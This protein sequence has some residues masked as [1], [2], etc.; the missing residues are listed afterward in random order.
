[1]SVIAAEERDARWLRSSPGLILAVGV[2]IALVIAVGAILIVLQPPLG[3]MATLVATLA[4]TSILSLAAGFFLY[5]R[6][7]AS[8]PSLSL[9]LLLTYAWAAILTLINVW[10]LAGLMFYSKHDLALAGILLIFAGIIA[11]TFGVFVAAR[12]TGDLRQLSAAAHRLADGDLTARATVSGRDEV[13]QVAVAFNEMADQMQLASE[14][15]ADV[16]NLRRDLIAWTSHD[17]RTPLTSIRVMIEALNDGLVEDEETKVRYYR[18]IR[19]EIVALNDLIDDLFELAQLDAGG[20]ELKLDPQ[21]L[22]DLISDTLESFRPIAERRSVRLD[23][24]VEGSVDPVTMNAPKISR[25]LSNLVDNAIQHSPDRGEVYLK[26]ARIDQGVQVEVFDSGPGFSQDELPRVFEKF[27]RGE[28]ARS[29]AKGGAGLGLAIAYG[30]VA[31]HGGQI[32]AANRETGGA[33]VGFI[34]PG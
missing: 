13:S 20:I 3:E 26:A 17:L 29:R 10:I 22:S 2:S 5:R 11:M 34:L 21:S 9:T 4:L 23:G 24:S 25:V 19:G 18:T 1:M 30:I 7:W 6:G 27:Y 31:A 32:W 16:E 8:S 33:L 28:S 12:V 14:E 15:R